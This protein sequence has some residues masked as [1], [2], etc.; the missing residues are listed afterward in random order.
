MPQGWLLS[1]DERRALVILASTPRGATEAFL[2]ARG[3][4]RETIAGLL[5]AGLV[6][7]TPEAVRLGGC[8]VEID[9]IRITETGRRALAG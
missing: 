9:R 7:A 5:H 4:T 1:G 6:T 8:I 2:L 3:C